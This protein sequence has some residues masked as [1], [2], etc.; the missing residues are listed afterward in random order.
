MKLQPKPE[1][2]QHWRDERKTAVRRVVDASVPWVVVMENIVTGK[3]TKVFRVSEWGR[4]S[5]YVF[6]PKSPEVATKEQQAQDEV[7][8]RFSPR[9]GPRLTYC[10]KPVDELVTTTLDNLAFWRKRRPIC[11]GCDAR[12]RDGKTTLGEIAGAA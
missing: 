1:K 3:R 7:H 10:M 8:I 11:Q 12:R 5:G 9:D 4:P 6:V 2:G